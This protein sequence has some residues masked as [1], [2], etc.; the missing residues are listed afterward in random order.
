M[1]RKK[2][3]AEP[4]ASQAQEPGGLEITAESPEPTAASEARI[5]QE[6]EHRMQA[7]SPAAAQDV[8]AEVEAQAADTFEQAFD[9]A[10]PLGAAVEDLAR[11]E[12]KEKKTANKPKTVR[13]PRKAKVAGGDEIS[14]KPAA[15]EESPTD[16][17]GA[18]ADAAAPVETAAAHAEGDA[19]DAEFTAEPR[20]PAKLERLQKILSQAG[21]ASRRHAEELITE[22]RV[23]VNGKI[24]TELGSKADPGRDH[25][26]VDGKLLRGAERLRYFV[27]N[28]PRGYVTTVSDPEKRS[29]VMEFFARMPERL[30]PV[31]RLD[32]LSEGLLLVTNDG[33]LANKL[34]KA[35]SGVQKT[36][37]VKV[38][39]QPTEEELDRLRE[40]VSIERG[41]P[42]EGRVS[43]APATIR[44]ARAGDNPWFEVVLI[45]GRNRELRKMFEEIGHHVEKIRR[46]GYGP[47]VLDQEPGKFRELDPAELAQLRL[48]AEGKWRQPKAKEEQRGRG[49]E[50]GGSAFRADRPRKDR[51]FERKPERPSRPAPS[52]EEKPPRR[53]GDWERRPP[54]R[55]QPEW[56]R[57]TRPTRAPARFN[58]GERPPRTPARF[59]EGDRSEGRRTYAS[60]PPAAF[61]RAG[62]R[63]A[64]QAGSRPVASRPAQPRREG[65]DRPAW[66]RSER[67]DR[68][69]R[70]D[71]GDSRATTGRF[72]RPRG[73]GEKA[74]RGSTRGA[75]A[76]PQRPGPQ[77]PSQFRAG[78]DRAERPRFER[79]DTGRGGFGGARPR[80][81][82]ASGPRPQ[83]ASGPRPQGASP[84]PQGGSGSRPQGGSGTRT[85]PKP[86]W[87]K[88]GGTSRPAPDGRTRPPSRPGGPAKFG[89][90]GPAGRSGPGRSGPGRGGDQRGGT[91]R[92]RY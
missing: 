77:R 4:D 82:G 34:T 79:A 52:A 40:G 35:A 33:D 76:R 9:S 36:Y 39:G 73:E 80:P 90:R 12:G 57:G 45:E 41:K 29:T 62:A 2:K 71:R 6:A 26:R 64:G 46:V 15:G 1:P 21:V 44:K 32:Y 83:G 65:A 49:G 17:A 7:E 51:G 28:K 8:E 20:P 42:G 86:A 89:G 5:D 66:K 11:T 59:N 68:P 30:Y 22:G 38:S 37:L 50:R 3:I 58:E 81:Q 43:T 55:Q 31:G 25:I 23:Q 18:A 53:T 69:F 48:A 87:K 74:D 85:G 60:K 56:Q 91:G 61:G 88:T 27:L 75:G 67:G 24:V 63:G 47:L 19:E 16:A 10:E 72:D 84:R 70:T 14:P 92:R 54:T 13:K 78:Q